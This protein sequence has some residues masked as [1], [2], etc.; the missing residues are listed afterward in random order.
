MMALKIIPFFATFLFHLND[1]HC[2]INPPATQRCALAWL[3]GRAGEGRSKGPA[4]R[5]QQIGAA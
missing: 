3:L 5:G 4:R 2:G 1:F